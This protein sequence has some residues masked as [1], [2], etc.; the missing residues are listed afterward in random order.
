[1][2]PVVGFQK[3]G[4]GDCNPF[5]AVGFDGKNADFEN[6]AAGVFE[7]CRV[8]ELAHD[9]FIYVAGLVS[10]EEF[11]LGLF[12]IDFHGEF[13]D[14]RGPLGMGKTNVPSSREGFGL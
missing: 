6:V 14:V 12:A 3:L 4:V 7:Q 1:M 8:L 9:V 11:G 10:G 5:F 2:R 13:V